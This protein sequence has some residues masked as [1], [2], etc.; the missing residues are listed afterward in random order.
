M[1]QFIIEYW[2]DILLA[3]ITAAT[4]ALGRWLWKTTQNQ[5]KTQKAYTQANI[6][7]LR[8]GLYADIE[9][10]NEKK[11]CPFWMRENIDAAF[12]EYQRLGGN[13][14]MKNMVD[15]VYDLPT[16]KSTTEQEK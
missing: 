7:L 9:W 14:M 12:R 8:R 13:G 2:D 4:L 15:D 5:Q 6:I 3:I 11:Y 1:Q 16:K 10:C